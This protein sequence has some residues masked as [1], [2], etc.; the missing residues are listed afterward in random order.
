MQISRHAYAPDG[1]C[2]HVIPDCWQRGRHKDGNSGASRTGDVLAALH[3]FRH[4]L[5]QSSHLQ[6]SLTKQVTSPMW[7]QVFISFPDS[8]GFAL[9]G[10][11]MCRHPGGGTCDPASNSKAQ[12]Y[13]GYHQGK[14]GDQRTDCRRH[15]RLILPRKIETVFT[16][17][18]RGGAFYWMRSNASITGTPPA[19]STW[20]QIL[21]HSIFFTFFCV[22]KHLHC[23]V[24]VELVIF[25]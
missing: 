10:R 13:P 19:D 17:A 14:A 9:F 6:T 11:H 7:Q 16:V 21:V 5:R 20:P 18:A 25:D 1:V 4:C 15:P 2:R 22:R 8:Q 12:H 3:K 24:D 23:G